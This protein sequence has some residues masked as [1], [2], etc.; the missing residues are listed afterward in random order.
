[1]AATFA[2]SLAWPARDGTAAPSATVSGS[3]RIPLSLSESVE[4]G[5]I[6]PFRSIPPPPPHDELAASLA[7]TKS[8]TLFIPRPPTPFLIIPPRP[9]PACIIIY[10][11]SPAVDP[12]RGAA[13]RRRHQHLRQRRLLRRTRR[14][15]DPDT[16]PPPTSAAARHLQLDSPMRPQVIKFCYR[17]R[18]TGHSRNGKDDSSQDPKSQSPKSQSPSSPLSR[19]SLSTPAIPTYHAGGF[20]EI[21]HE[22]LPP[23]TPIHLKSIR[24]VKVS[25]Y[26]SLDITVSFPS[27][28]ALRSFFSSF[29]VPSDGPDLD[30]RFVMS[31]NHAARI[32]RRRVAEQELEGEMHQDS[33]W[34]VNPCLYDFSAAYSSWKEK[35]HKVVKAN[36]KLEKQVLSLKDTY[37]NVVQKKSKLKKEVRSL[38][39]KCEFVVG[40]NDKLE[41]QMA[42]LSSSFLS[43]KE[44]FLLANNGDKLKVGIDQV[45]VAHKDG[46]QAI[47]IG[48]GDQTGQQADVT[49]V[50][51]GEKRTT[52]KSSFRICKPQGTFL[53]PSMGSGTDMSGGG[54]SGISVPA[55]GPLPRSG[56]GSCPSIGQGLPPSSRAPVEVL[57]ESPLD[58]HVM[59]GGDYF[60]TPPSA[61][62]TTNATKLLPLPSPRSPLQPQPLFSAAALHSFAGLTLRH[63]DSP[64]S[65]PSPCGASLLQGAEA[66]GMSTV[67]TELALATPFYC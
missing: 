3:K 19:Q 48:G 67:R 45:A 40:K 34:L 27:I 54:S 60:S 58:E 21:D 53:W 8:P 56:S 5:T 35:Y 38:K 31:S 2:S 25:E 63:M 7:P 10:F 65:L 61:S 9:V 36:E 1:M 46:K 51:A 18:P 55:S 47:S 39:D 30:E 33:F 22:R 6:C 12:T 4:H 44:Q 26:T 49:V 57:I 11:H 28:L 16:A 32:L 37:E 15:M 29:P 24:V 62:S 50:Q 14:Q 43:L 13:P 66:G 64:S 17:K 59:G 42:S 52:R 41:E 20:Y 23:R